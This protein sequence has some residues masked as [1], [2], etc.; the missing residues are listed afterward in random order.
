MIDTA[1]SQFSVFA[2]SMQIS[3]RNHGNDR[4]FNIL[5]LTCSIGSGHIS[6]ARAIADALERTHGDAVNV[7]IV[8]FVTDLPNFATNTTKKV[9]LGSLKFSPKIH[10][11]IFYHSTDHTWPITLMNALTMPFLEQKFK[12]FVEVRRP[13]MVVSTFPIWDQL[14]K[15]VWRAYSKTAPFISVITD[16]ISVHR[17]WTTGNPDF[18]IVANEDTKTALQNF[19]VNENLIK[20]LGYPIAEKFLRPASRNAFLKEWRLSPQKKTLLMIL[21]TGINWSKIKK[22]LVRMEHSKLKNV[23]MMVVAYGEKS[24]EKKLAEVKW[25]WTTRITGWTDDMATFIHAADVV[26]TKAGGATVME[27]I[28]SKKPMLIID[29]LPGQELGNAVLVEKYNLGT[30]LSDDASDFE[31]SISYI[32]DHDA[33][34]KRN[35]KAQQKPH[36]AEDIAEFLFSLLG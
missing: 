9:Y 31:S 30:V 25:P 12:R 22:L 8:D 34:I 18:F 16:S 36:A 15:K 2:R 32:L 26:L 28:Q 29:V 14:I 13:D 11:H 6:V 35:L 20:V 21:P 19:E 1:S 33:L 17:V 5:I 4:A 3:S 7:E 23:Q 24:W 10:E 27:C